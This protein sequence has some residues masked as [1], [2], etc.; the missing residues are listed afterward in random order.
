MVGVALPTLLLPSCIRRHHCLGWVFTRSVGLGKGN[1][2]SLC[3][4]SYLKVG[5]SPF[6]FFYGLLEGLGLLKG[7]LRAL[8][9]SAWIGFMRMN[10][11][12]CGYSYMYV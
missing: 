12:I 2:K 3:M 11:F 4:K 7:V 5:I 10:T 9:A 6:L 1:K 8:L